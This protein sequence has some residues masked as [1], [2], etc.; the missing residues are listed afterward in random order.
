MGR[1]FDIAGDLAAIATDHDQAR[2][3]G[4]SFFGIFQDETADGGPRGGPVFVCA[5]REIFDDELSRDVTQQQ[6]ISVNRRTYSDWVDY[7]I[8]ARQPDGRGFVRLLLT[9][10]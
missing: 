1:P 6:T 8:D 7:Y 5:A 9:P 3:G 10:V 4:R 2:I